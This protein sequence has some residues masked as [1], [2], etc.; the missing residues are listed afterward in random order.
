[1]VLLDPAFKRHSTHEFAFVIPRPVSKGNLRGF[2]LGEIARQPIP[3][4]LRFA[5]RHFDSEVPM[6]VLAARDFALC[7]SGACSGC[8]CDGVHKD[9]VKVL[10][11]VGSVPF[12][13]KEAGVKVLTFQSRVFSGPNVVNR[14]STLRSS[15][16]FSYALTYLFDPVV[17]VKALI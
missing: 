7:L 5:S 3:G 15:K 13:K 8:T 17:G 4:M 16:P 14:Q 11:K 12:G 6:F 2:S 1:M 9:A 10:N